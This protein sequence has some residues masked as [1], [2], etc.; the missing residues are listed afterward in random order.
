MTI[1]YAKVLAELGPTRD[2]VL[3]DFRGRGGDRDRW[4]RVD[5]DAT[6]HALTLRRD[7]RLTE[8]RE[9]GCAFFSSA[10]QAR[11]G[12]CDRPPSPPGPSDA[13]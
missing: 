13:F 8:G 2:S 4:S 3:A 7:G 6:A 5:R 12:G 11:F 10:R 1:S 9:F